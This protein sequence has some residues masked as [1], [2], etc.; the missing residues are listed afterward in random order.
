MSLIGTMIKLLKVFSVY[1]IY[2]F[3]NNIKEKLQL[4]NRKIVNH[5]K[6]KEQCI[7]YEGNLYAH[8]KSFKNLKKVVFSVL[9]G[10][11]DSISTFNVQKGFDYYLFTD[12]L[13]GKFNHTN[14]TI[15]PIPEEVQ[16]LNVSRFKKQRFIKLHPHLYFK[17]YDISIYFDSN[18][19]IIEDLNIFLIRILSPKYNIYCLEHPERNSV[20]NETYAV[21][22]HIKEKESIASI[23]REK[24]KKEKYPDENGLIEGCLIIRKHNE[25]DS[26]YLM[27]KWYE[28]I[29]N[30]SHR[31]QLSFNYVLWK[32][33]LKIKYIAKNYALQ[34]FFQNTT[35]LKL[36][37]F[38]D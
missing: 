28:E 30:Y 9:L 32:T 18:F 10:E 2:N 16:K 14:W 3:N 34:Y 1:M 24:Y 23:V 33:R 20:F 13:N 31:D 15:V 29:N 19:K 4:L 35:H 5:I 12:N 6:E 17:D 8:L 7:Y 36:L 25:N 38:K 26:I 37:Q 22:Q 21:V 11:Y 27:N